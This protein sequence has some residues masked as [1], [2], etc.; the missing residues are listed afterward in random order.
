MTFPCS[1][2]SIYKIDDLLS[3]SSDGQYFFDFATVFSVAFNKMIHHRI[4]SREKSGTVQDAVWNRVNLYDSAGILYISDLL[5]T[6]SK[7][8]ARVFYQVFVFN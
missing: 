3:F 4:D 7:M 1:Y 2:I 8:S 6:A 5:L